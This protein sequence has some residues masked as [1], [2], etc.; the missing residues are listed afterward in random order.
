LNLLEADAKLVAELRLG[1]SLLDAP[2]PNSLSQF[3][4]GFAGTALLH[5]LCR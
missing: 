5:P 4:V 1:D 3:N 2:Q